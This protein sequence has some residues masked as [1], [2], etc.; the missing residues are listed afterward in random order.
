MCFP[1]QG[2]QD[3]SARPTVEIRDLLV[4]VMQV[5]KPLNGCWMDENNLCLSR[6]RNDE[7]NA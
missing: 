2:K 5:L 6:S 1:I 7:N 3:S 4:G